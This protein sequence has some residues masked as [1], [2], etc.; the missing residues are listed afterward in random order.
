M[1]IDDCILPPK[2]KSD[3][4]NIIKEG[5]IPNMTFF[6]TAGLGKTTAAI[7][8]C[9]QLGVDYIKINGSE[10]N[11]I[12][13]LR[14][15]IRSFASTISLQGGYKVVILDE[16][17]FLNA[18]STQP[19]LRGF[20]EEFGNNCRFILTCN[21]K[22]RLIPAMFSRCPPIN[23]NSTKKE[24]ASLAGEYLKRI[25]LILKNENVVADE[26]SIVQIILAHAPD[27]RRVLNECQTF[28]KS[29][30]LEL[31]A[32]DAMHD[33]NFKQLV[34]YL[35]DKD[36]K[37][38][39]TWVVE[40]GAVDNTVLFRRIYDNLSDHADASSIP[41]AVLILADYGYKSAFVSD[42]EINC[43]ACLTELMSSVSWK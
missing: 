20:I 6:G 19:A 17:D 31:D 30:K 37:N 26:K 39:R 8:I 36:F 38:M 35:K 43:V 24:L 27:W 40:N 9:E 23:F 4:N 10:E 22:N 16:A 12:D 13:V 5:Q 18:N 11:G 25:K 14:G 34:A 15:K 28:S 42:K 33:D 21:F 2:L 7:A 41:S 1:S 32:R 3:L 29:G